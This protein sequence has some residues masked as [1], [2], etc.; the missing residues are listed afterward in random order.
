VCGEESR[1]G[2]RVRRHHGDVMAYEEGVDA[3][4]RRGRAGEGGG[5]QRRFVDRTV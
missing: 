5:G 2:G 3:Q 4:R 1:G